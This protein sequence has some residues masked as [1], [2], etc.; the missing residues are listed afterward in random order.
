MTG[1]L[2]WKNVDRW[3][4]KITPLVRSQGVARTDIVRAVAAMSTVA[5]LLAAVF[6]VA[7]V[8]S[9]LIGLPR[10]LGLP[11]AGRFVGAVLV[12]AGVA[13]AYWVFRYRSPMAMA[14][15]TYVTF[16]KLFGLVPVT[17][18]SGRVE[19]L[20]VVGPQRYTRN[21]LYL[22]VILVTSGWALMGEDAFVLIGAVV[23]LLFFRLVLI[24]FE[25]REL[26]ALFGEQYRK[27]SDEVPM[28]IPFTKRKR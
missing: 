13:V 21:P 7:C 19:P 12:A 26:R 2:L 17:E 23:L 10:L 3:S 20:V 25:E 14:V 4:I 9:G 6:Y 18:P 11:L 28:L 27:Y 1:S 24:P 15:S 8:A 16:T 5:F 22:G